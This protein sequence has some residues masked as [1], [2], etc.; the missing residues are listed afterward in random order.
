MRPTSRASR[1]RKSSEAATHLEHDGPLL[2]VGV[3]PVP[4]ERARE[5]AVGQRHLWGQRRGG[6]RGEVVG[7]EAV[8]EGRKMVSTR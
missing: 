3:V 2:H 5:G 1:P 8:R 4:E 6:V 7:F